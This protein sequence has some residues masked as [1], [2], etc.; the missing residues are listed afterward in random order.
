MTRQIQRISISDKP[1]P[2]GYEVTLLRR[3]TVPEVSSLP[4]S[5]IDQKV[6]VESHVKRSSNSIKRLSDSMLFT[7]INISAENRQYHVIKI[8]NIPWCISLNN[9]KSILS[10]LTMPNPDKFV[11]NIHIMMDKHTGKTLDH[12]YIEVLSD[13]ETIAET[14]K[15]YRRPPVKGRKLCLTESSQDDLMGD[16]Y[17]GWKDSLGVGS[18]KAISNDTN[19]QSQPGLIEREDYEALLAVCRDFK[20]H[21]SRKCAERPFEHFISLLVKYPWDQPHR[22]TTLQRDHLYEY[23][24]QATGILKEH[25]SRYHT[26]FD[27]TLLQRMI[28]G[29][30]QSP[31][32]TV[33]QKKGVL[34]ASACT[35]PEDLSHLLI[36]KSPE[37]AATEDSAPP[38]GDSFFSFR[39]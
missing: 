32:L 1:R 21:F 37:T 35:C 36:Q 10:N 33:P 2:P 13:K 31:G 18:F 24:K 5:Q 23:Y 17:P 9:I 19:I 30:I 20:L 28:R 27:S 15:F 4:V 12:A 39:I 8:S 14:I 26:I 29:A 16:L 22:I 7:T 3:K 25:L 6:K 38:F 34:K 11:Q